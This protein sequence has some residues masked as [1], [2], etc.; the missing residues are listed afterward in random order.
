MKS[1][2]LEATICEWL[3]QNSDEIEKSYGIYIDDSITSLIKQVCDTIFCAMK[4]QSDL[5][6]KNEE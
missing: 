2:G 3:K 6:R 5:I 4:Y 1:H